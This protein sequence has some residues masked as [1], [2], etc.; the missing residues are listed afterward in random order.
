M[1]TALVLGCLTTALTLATGA[2]GRDDRL[3][4]ASDGAE[5][6]WTA[7]TAEG[8]NV[9]WAVLDGGETW[10][11]Y[12]AQGTILG[13]FHGQTHASGGALHGT[14]LAFDIPS[15]TLGETTFT[16]SYLPRQAIT[17]TTGFGL[18]VNGRYAA[19]YEQP[20]RLPELQ[21]RYDGEGLSS[22]SPVI[23]LQMKVD[24]D[25]RFAMTSRGDCA[26]RGTAHPH[27]GGKNVFKVSLRFA[28]SACPLG[29][30]AHAAGI[31]HLSTAS[32]ELFLLAMN[33]YHTDGWLYLGV[34]AAD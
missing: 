23:D 14:G 15:G 31:A 12:E 29:D 3:P 25:G 32:G 28:G 5:G 22:H 9:K 26:A 16:G 20:A 34:R 27:P 17:L 18:T 33:R 2:A 6:F 30:G 24:A 8:V 1:R 13:A 21:G 19:R 10:G 4:A 7:T 11:I